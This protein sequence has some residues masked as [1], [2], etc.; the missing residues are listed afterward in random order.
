MCNSIL[1]TIK[2]PKLQ[3]DSKPGIRPVRSM[4]YRQDHAMREH[5]ETGTDKTLA[6]DVIEPAISK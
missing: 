2:P 5:T 3:I 1:G 6:E 4:P